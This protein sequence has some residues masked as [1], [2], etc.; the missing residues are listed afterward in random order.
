MPIEDNSGSDGARSAQLPLQIPSGK[1]HVYFVQPAKVDKTGVE[2]TTVYYTVPDGTKFKFMARNPDIRADLI[3]LG[4]R[5]DLADV[6][7]EFT[8]A[9][10][11][12]LTVRVST[13]G[14]A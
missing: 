11:G 3:A 7:E 10:G 9:K 8:W 14:G 12:K 6:D 2:R 1:V 4:K 13:R 5:T